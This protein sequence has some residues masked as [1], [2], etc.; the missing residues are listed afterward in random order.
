MSIIVTANPACAKTCAIPLP[1]CPA[2]TTAMRSV[3]WSRLLAATP[4][5]IKVEQP[6]KHAHGGGGAPFRSPRATRRPR[7]AIAHRAI[8]RR[9]ERDAAHRGVEGNGHDPVPRGMR[10]PRG[11]QTVEHD[12]HRG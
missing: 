6:G 9:V 7:G 5:T 2:P 12:A 10:G 8:V 1:I 3:T 11:V 4:R